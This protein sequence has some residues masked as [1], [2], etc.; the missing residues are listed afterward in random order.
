MAEAK[1]AAEAAQI[2]AAQSAGIVSP[3]RE[4]E[5]T[6]RTALERNRVAYEHFLAET[7]RAKAALEEARGRLVQL[8]TDLA[9]AEQALADAVAAEARL[10]AEDRVLAEVSVAYPD[11]A[12][13]A[14]SEAIEATDRARTRGAG[15]K[16]GD[17]GGC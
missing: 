6:S 1:T 4:Q 5:A 2:A 14:E 8:R 17:P 15:G 10:V 11:K 9:H 16:S 3:L 12:G 7:E 13:A